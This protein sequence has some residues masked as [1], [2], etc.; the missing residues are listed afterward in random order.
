MTGK[1]PLLRTMR[2]SAPHRPQHPCSISIPRPAGLASGGPLVCPALK[3]Q[4]EVERAAFRIA[5][6]ALGRRPGCSR[7]GDLTLRRYLHKS[8]YFSWYMQVY[9]FDSLLCT[10]W[11]RKTKDTRKYRV[12]TRLVAHSLEFVNSASNVRRIETS[13]PTASCSR[14]NDSAWKFAGDP[15]RKG[16]SPWQS[17]PASPI[18]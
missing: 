9:V 8:A 2:A 14:Y 18:S 7:P 5:W 6:R 12:C 10:P 13:T 4:R 1:T 17:S 16:Y 11:P 3:E 15:H